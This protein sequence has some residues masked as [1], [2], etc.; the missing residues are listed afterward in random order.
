[1]Q[2]LHDPQFPLSITEVAEVKKR[3]DKRF[4]R[5]LLRL[6]LIKRQFKK[7]QS[8]MESCDYSWKQ[9]FKSV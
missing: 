2:T 5:D 9:L 8:I 6:M 7:G 1:M 3:V 4:G